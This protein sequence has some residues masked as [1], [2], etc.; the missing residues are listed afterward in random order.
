MTDRIEV[1]SGELVDTRDGYTWQ[2]VW[3]ELD[4]DGIKRF[5]KQCFGAR[6]SDPEQVTDEDEIKD[7]IYEIS[8]SCS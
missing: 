8:K 2:N 6:P 1:I 4:Y 3:Y 5:Y 7:L